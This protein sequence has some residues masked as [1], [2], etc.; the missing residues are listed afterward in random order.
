[1]EWC[2]SEGVEYVFGMGKNSRLMGMIRKEL[3]KVAR[4]WVERGKKKGQRVYKELRYK[5]LKTWSRKRRVVAKAEYTEGKTNPRFVVTSL[6]SGEYPAGKLYGKLYCGRGEMENRIKEQQLWLFADRTSSATMRAN[7]LRL[8]FSSVAYVMMSAL[9]RMG[10]KGTDMA[11]A[12]CHNIGVKLLKIGAQVVFSARRIVVRMA[13][14][15]P[16][17]QSYMRIVENL[18]TDTT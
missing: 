6:G 4:R 7:Q 8:W 14:S 2:E 15:S 13:G 16:L 11:R 18:S 3:N 5:T 12:Q 10:L 1:M 17:Q 9:R